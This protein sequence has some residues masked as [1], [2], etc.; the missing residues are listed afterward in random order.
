M[1]LGRRHRL[2]VGFVCSVLAITLT[3]WISSA[4]TR[5]RLAPA[6]GELPQTLQP[7][8]AQHPVPEVDGAQ[9]PDQ[10]PD[11]VALSL[12]YRA[13]VP[14]AGDE[15][16]SQSRAYLRHM[17]AT[18]DAFVA[19][20]ADGVMDIERLGRVSMQLQGQNDLASR[21]LEVLNRF[22]PE[23]SALD[24]ELARAG[25]TQARPGD[26]TRL[27]EARAAGLARFAAA[28]TES[29]GPDGSERVTNALLKVKKGTRMFRPQSQ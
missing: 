15:G 6:S 2:L 19:A 11:A 13:A 20:R 9:T 21:A 22:R 29:L 1:S 8:G 5:H 18:D 17:L 3:A 26:L 16:L 23:I 25:R 7:H 4:D 27:K 28:L 12:F 10:I 14:R 24:E